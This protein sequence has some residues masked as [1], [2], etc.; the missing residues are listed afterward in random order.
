MLGHDA[1]PDITVAATHGLLVGDAPQRLAKLPL[2][3]LLVTDSVTPTGG[4]TIAPLLADAITGLHCGH[5]PDE[6]VIGA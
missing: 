1:L 4:A 3:A 6:V 5:A 2:R